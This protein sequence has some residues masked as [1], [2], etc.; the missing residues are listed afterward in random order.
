MHDATATA[1]YHIQITLVEPDG[2]GERSAR[3]ENPL[4]AQITHPSLAEPI[5]YDLRLYLGLDCMQVHACSILICHLIASC[6]QLLATPVNT[7]GTNQAAQTSLLAIV[8]GGDEVLQGVKLLLYGTPVV[9]AIDK[10]VRWKVQ[11][12]IST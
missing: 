5:V 4:L 10:G 7:T 6:Q 8:P 12:E 3:P 1:R 9:E 11:A 2:V